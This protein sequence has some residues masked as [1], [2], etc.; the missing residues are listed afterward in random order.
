V[1]ARDNEPKMPVIHAAD[2]WRVG[3]H[4]LEVVMDISPR[5]EIHREPVGKRVVA[6]AVMVDDA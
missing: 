6:A 2:P 5:F 4:G 1:S 3:Q